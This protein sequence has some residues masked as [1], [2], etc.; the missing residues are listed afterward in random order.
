[1]S[2]LESVTVLLCCSS[3]WPPLYPAEVTGVSPG[4]KLGCSVRPVDTPA[5]APVVGS[6]TSSPSS[7]VPVKREFHSELSIPLE[8]EVAVQE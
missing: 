3:T 6:S 7:S 5:G 2:Q 8:L 4:T 1:M